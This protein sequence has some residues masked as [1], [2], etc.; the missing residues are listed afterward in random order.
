MSH[1][2]LKD[3]VIQ[4]VKQGKFSIWA[5]ENVFEALEILLNRPFFADEENV[6]QEAS[7]FEL[8]H[9]YVDEFQQ[10][11]TSG[12]FWQKICKIF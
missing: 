4:A 7:L 9:Q 8:V 12:S 10:G 6:K 2:S 11:E 1:L 3:D 5:V